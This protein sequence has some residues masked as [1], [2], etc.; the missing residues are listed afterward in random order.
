MASLKSFAALSFDCYGTLVDWEGGIIAALQPLTKRLDPTHPLKTDGAALLQKYGA[1]ES[2]IQKQYTT[3]KYSAILER[4]YGEIASELGL[5]ASVTDDE[6]VAFG[7]SIGHWPAFPDTITALKQLSRHFKLIILSNVDKESFARTLS[8]PLAGIPFDAIYVA[9]EIGSYKPDPRNFEY[10][11][12]HCESDLQV[13]R[14]KLLHT[15][16]ALFH[17]LTPAKRAGLKTCWIERK[18]NVM[19]GEP[20]QLDSDISLDFRFPTLG[21]MAREL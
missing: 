14:D 8:G 2:R 12:E 13:P 15:A 6:K 17:D 19:G 21:D 7:A 10:L 18:P 11:M 5:D 16:Y 1:H 4:V 20:S 3:L 9:E